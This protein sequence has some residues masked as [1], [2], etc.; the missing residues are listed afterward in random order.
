MGSATRIS[1]PPIVSDP[2]CS[3]CEGPSHQQETNKPLHVYALAKCMPLLSVYALAKCMYALAK[4]M[5]LLSDT[6]AKCI[7]LLSVYPC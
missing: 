5:P 1:R 7:P 4:C 3:V 6:L 2:G